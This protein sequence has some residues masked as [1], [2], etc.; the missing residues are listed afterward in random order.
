MESFDSLGTDN[1]KKLF[2]TSS[3]NHK[4]IK[5][6]KFN[7]TQLQSSISDTCGFFVLY[8]I[9]NRYHNQDLNFTELLN[10]IFTQNIEHNET[11]VK[12]FAQ[13]HFQNE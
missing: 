4:T 5:K 13:E 3:F 11:V 9:V 6:I 8:F 12:N 2:L 10:E 1:E 7:V